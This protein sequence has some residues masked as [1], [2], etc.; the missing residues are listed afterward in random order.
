MKKRLLI[1]PWILI[2][3]A[4]FALAAGYFVAQGS[5][6][7]GS[8]D[9]WAWLLYTVF[10]ANAVGLMLVKPSR[11][12]TLFLVG[13]YVSAGSLAALVNQH[14][15]IMFV[16]ICL[17]AP[18]RFGRKLALGWIAMCVAAVVT[19]ELWHTAES[20]SVQ[21]ALMNGFLTL[22]IGGFA[23]VRKESEVAKLQAVTLTAQLQQKNQQLQALAAERE[24]RLRIEE[25]QKLS[26]EL[27]DTLGHK[28]TTS[29][30]QLEAAEGF[31]ERDPER[32]ES[33]LQTV[34]D[35]LKEGLAETRDIVYLLDTAPAGTNSLAVSIG[36][37]ARQF[38]QSTGLE[39]SLHLPNSSQTLAPDVQQHI[40]RIVLEALTN[41]ARHA[42]ATRVDIELTVKKCIT[43]YV[44][45]NGSALKNQV[46]E[47]LTPARSIASRIAELQGEVSFRLEGVYTRLQVTIPL[48]EEYKNND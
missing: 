20:A 26:R 1:S 39:V 22:F 28:L 3:T 7:Q 4:S 36:S 40:E 5:V 44:T 43:L 6:A 35:L 42:N 45:D 2:A 23:L 47:S 21:D 33:I 30:V 46:G 19:L 11:W 10:I 34:R 17:L 13:L 27:H 18:E 37:I 41:V 38:E 25:R 8:P 29:I 31:L 9:Y 15:A 14:L 12:L 24:G 32:T 16:V 48:G